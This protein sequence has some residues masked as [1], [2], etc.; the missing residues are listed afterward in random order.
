MLTRKN[1]DT[2]A[3]SLTVKGQGE[4]FTFDLVFYNKGK[5]AITELVKQ[6]NEKTNN[7]FELS[8]MMTAVDIVES[9]G[10]EKPTVQTFEELEEQWPGFIDGLFVNY[11]LARRVEVVKN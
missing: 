7:D 5:K 8:N 1:P 4:Q 9:I 2:L 10:G 11:H 3:V 6:N